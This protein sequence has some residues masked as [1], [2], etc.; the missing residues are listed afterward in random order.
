MISVVIPAYNEAKLIKGCLKA[1]KHQ[2]YTGKY[3]IMVVDGG[4]DDGTQRTARK[5]GARVVAEYGKH[6]CPGNARNVGVSKS[7][8]GIVAFI[9]ADCV[10]YPNWLSRIENDFN[11]NVIAIGGIVRPHHGTWLDRLMF[12]LLSDWWVRVS[13]KLGTYQLYGNNCAYRK[14]KFLEI[15][16]FDTDISFFEDTDLS[17]RIKKLGRIWIDKD[18]NVET[19]TRRFRKMGYAKLF[20]INTSA[21]FN[22]L[23]GKPITTKYF[24]AHK[25]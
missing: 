18:L 5:M 13:A 17:M 10:A 8:Y 19:S 21:F 14:D 25:K 4:S 22:S 7:K 3:E 16:G 24:K 1:L 11:E 9:D 2:D 20:W 15:G 12:K 6:K 23:T